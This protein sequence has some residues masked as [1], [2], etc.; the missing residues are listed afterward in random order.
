MYVNGTLL[1]QVKDN[2]A[3]QNIH[4]IHCKVETVFSKVLFVKNNL[5]AMVLNASI[6]MLRL[7]VSKFLGNR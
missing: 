3:T 6:H 2:V 7:L 1:L 4:I 5:L